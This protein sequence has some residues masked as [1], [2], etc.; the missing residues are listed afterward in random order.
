MAAAAGRNYL[1]SPPVRTFSYLNRWFIFRRR[2]T[3]TMLSM[4]PP[5]PTEVEQIVE[6]EGNNEARML[7]LFEKR[8]AQS[9]HKL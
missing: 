8:L 3:T 9:G 4:P 6:E 5:V 7:E 2:S 1:M